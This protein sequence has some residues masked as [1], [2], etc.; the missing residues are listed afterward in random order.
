MLLTGLR[1]Q[2][3]LLCVK[4]GQINFCHHFDSHNSASHLPSG[5]ED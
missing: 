1:C 3:Q 2:L 4:F 5:A